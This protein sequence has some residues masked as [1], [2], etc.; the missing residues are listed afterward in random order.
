[1]AGACRHVWNHHTSQDIA[2]KY[3]TVF[4]E[5]LSTKG[6]TTSAKGKGKAAKAGLNREI[7]KSGWHQLEQMLSD[8]ANVI[9]V[10]AACTS[11]R[12]HGCGHTEKDNR[13][14][15]ADFICQACG[16][17]DNAALNVL[18]FA[19]GATACGGGVDVKRP[20][21]REM[22]RGVGFVSQSV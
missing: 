8:K 9:K 14:T 13:R 5:D 4:V 21:K 1:M 19:N 6:M 2:A 12:C 17:R 22:D 20:V 10:P 11:Q 3:T 18:T 16:H 7:L 15:Q